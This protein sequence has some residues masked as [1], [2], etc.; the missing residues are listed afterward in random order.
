MS[1]MKKVPIEKKEEQSPMG[2]SSPEKG[3]AKGEGR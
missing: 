1:T 2:A 3:G